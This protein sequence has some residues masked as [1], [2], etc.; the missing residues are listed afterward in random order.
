MQGPAKKLPTLVTRQVAIN[1]LVPAPYNP[2]SITP[3]ALKGLEES[4]TQFGLVEPIIWNEKT[5]HVVGGH[6]RLEVLK[7]M[8]VASTEVV[9]VDLN[10]DQERALNLT[11]NNDALMGTFN[12]GV[13]ELLASIKENFPAELYDTLQFGEIYFPGKTLE[14]V[15]GADIDYGLAG[16]D[17]SQLGLVEGDGGPGQNEVYTLRLILSGDQRAEL[18]EMVRW[19]AAKYGITAPTDVIFR[20]VRDAYNYHRATTDG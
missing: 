5:G 10:E 7:H 2:R 19:L 15:P 18:V 14:F 9:V 4:V 16:T 1:E 3:M 6:Q 20:A 13:S 8:G 11:L 12:E 17:D